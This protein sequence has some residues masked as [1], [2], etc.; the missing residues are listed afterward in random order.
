MKAALRVVGI[1]A[2]Y[3][4]DYYDGSPSKG[5]KGISTQGGPF[6]YSYI[7]KKNSHPV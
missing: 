1:G 4:Y 3:L 7:N 5:G 6:T 2:A